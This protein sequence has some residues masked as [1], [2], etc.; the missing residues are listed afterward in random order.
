MHIKVRQK[1]DFGEAVFKR[2]SETQENVLYLTLEELNA[3]RRYC[4]CGQYFDFQKA[5][6]GYPNAVAKV[7][8]VVIYQEK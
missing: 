3:L 4:T 5:A 7:G 1:L 2:I 8:F 6:V